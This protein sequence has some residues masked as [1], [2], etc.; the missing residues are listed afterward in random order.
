MEHTDTAPAPGPGRLNRAI[1]LRAALDLVDKHGLEAFSMRRLAHVLGRDPMAV[2]RHA[3]NR[4]EMLAGVAELVLDEVDAIPEDP[5]W[6]GQ[7]RRM[8]HELRR[9]CL[10][11]PNAVPLL[12]TGPL[13][14]PLGLRPPGTLRPLEKILAIL[15]RAGF[16]PADALHVSRAFYGFLYGHILGELQELIADPEENEAL[17]RLGLQRLPLRDFPH[18]RS[19]APEL[20]D[21]D[22][23]KELDQGITI[24]LAGLAQHH[25]RRAAP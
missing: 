21:Y 4:R 14:T 2:Y 25:T 11:H 3:E 13:S 5:D 22:G 24:L 19:L 8:A 17:L 1:V 15:I 23:A 20:L 12:V 6:Q 16:V 10:R 18:L 7:L 9:V